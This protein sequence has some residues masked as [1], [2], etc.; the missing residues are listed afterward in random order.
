MSKAARSIFK[1]ENVFSGR[2]QV[3]HIGHHAVTSAMLDEAK[4]SN[5]SATILQVDLT[6]NDLNPHSP[7]QIKEM[8][9]L[10]F[11]NEIESGQL[12]FVPLS[13]LQTG[14]LRNRETW[15]AIS[16]GNI[17]SLKVF[18]GKK[19]AAD[20]QIEGQHYIEFLA[21]QHGFTPVAISPVKEKFN[22]HAE[23]SASNMLR[24][25]YHKGFDKCV[26]PK[27]LKYMGELWQ[28][29]YLE[30]CL[31]AE[32]DKP[33]PDA[34]DKFTK[35]FQKGYLLALNRYGGVESVKAEAFLGKSMN[36]SQM[37]DKPFQR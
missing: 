7:K 22:G 31:V 36:E 11:P 14:S 18:F 19:S 35:G 20:D 10:I 32:V 37:V 24:N 3:P 33:N 28:T 12:Q 8:F 34:Y 16:G 4:K 26:S 13:S 5:S 15:E 9:R 30:G 6:P 27:I 23:I 1:F 29:A 17:S 21:Q 25:P 2:L